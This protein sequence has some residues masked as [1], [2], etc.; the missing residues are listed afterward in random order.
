MSQSVAQDKQAKE[1]PSRWLVGGFITV[2]H[3][4]GGDK[5]MALMGHQKCHFKRD[6]VQLT[7][8]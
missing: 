7:P 3:S 4:T 5:G 2:Q 8:A 1:S 6:T